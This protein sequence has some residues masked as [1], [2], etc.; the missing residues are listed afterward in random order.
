MTAFSDSPQRHL[1][2]LKP[3]PAHG[4]EYKA[5]LFCQLMLPNHP[6]I[7]QH[8]RAGFALAALLLVACA[9]LAHAWQDS[10]VMLPCTEASS[11]A[12]TGHFLASCAPAIPPSIIPWLAACPTQ[13]LT[14]LNAAAATHVQAVQLQSSPSQPSSTPLLTS[15]PTCYTRW[16]A[17]APATQPPWHW[18]QPNVVS[19]IIGA[20]RA[21]TPPQLSCLHTA[22]ITANCPAQMAQP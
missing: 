3:Q 18:L 15:P 10:V 8:Q 17:S 4:S 11:T 20:P 19:G 7:P 9:V 5:S 21:T 14:Q 2:R 1:R 22:A 12:L 16:S 13:C 6:G